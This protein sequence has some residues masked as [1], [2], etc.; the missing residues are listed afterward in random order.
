VGEDVDV[1]S[2]AS[3]MI[4]RPTTHMDMNM[5]ASALLILVGLAACG[6]TVA[7]GSDGQG[8]GADSSST[9]TGTGSS[10]SG[11]STGSSGSGTSTGTVT[12]KDGDAS[13][14]TKPH[15]N[16]CSMLESGEWSC[17]GDRSGTYEPCPPGTPGGPTGEGF[18]PTNCPSADDGLFCLAC[19]N[20]VGYL[21]DCLPVNPPHW[22]YDATF[23]CSQ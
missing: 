12:R 9:G 21:W 10:V 3:T 17:H 14:A 15:G 11:S 16:Y 1:C 18:A 7:N 2:N 19:M 8:S 23:T 6:G 20:G 22:E 4:H 5:K 13:D